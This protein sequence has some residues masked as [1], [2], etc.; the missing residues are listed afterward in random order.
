MET[1]DWQ[2]LTICV[3]A[4][5]LAGLGVY[6]TVAGYYH[7]RYYV[8][9]RSEPETWKCQ[10]KRFLTPALHRTAVLASTGNLTLAGAVTGFLVYGIV[11]GILSTPIY[12]DVSEYG[13]TYTIVMTVVLF[14]VTDCINYWMHRLL[15]VKFL[16]RRFH[17]FHHR[18]VAT[19]PYV[20]TAM[21]PVEVLAQQFASFVPLV[22]IPF[23][24]GSAVAVLLYILIF[25]IVDH[26][27]VKLISVLPW[28]PPSQYHDDHHAYFH[29][30]FGQHLMIW[31]RLFGTL[32]RQNR[33]YG[34]EIFGGH[35]VPDN[36]DGAAPA[37]LEAFIRY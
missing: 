12:T 24:A 20:T 30:N 31:D 34:K 36:T 3:G 19:S 28:Q 23:H 15:H 26:S 1:A 33:R 10:P 9:R 5:T 29:V 8:R 21:H 6:H 7:Y 27:G 25:N 2:V 37:G 17:R 13:W 32:R 14:V 18:F 4:A 16:Y 35:G 11:S 22:I